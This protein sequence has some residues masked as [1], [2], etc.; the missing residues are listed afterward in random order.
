MIVEHVSIECS[1]DDHRRSPILLRSLFDF[2]ETRL[3]IIDISIIFSPLIALGLIKW[4][5]FNCGR[6]LKKLLENYGH[7]LKL[8]VT[9]IMNTEIHFGQELRLQSQ[10]PSSLG[11]A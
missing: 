3:N 4:F 9:A 2:M 5:L 6:G 7:Q 1:A 8:K 11:S 10:I